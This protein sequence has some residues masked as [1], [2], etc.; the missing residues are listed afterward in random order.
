MTTKIVDEIGELVRLAN[1]ARDLATAAIQRLVTRRAMTDP[2]HRAEVQRLLD[3]VDPI[4]VPHPQLRIVERH[5]L[6]VHRAISFHAIMLQRSEA[7][8]HLGIRD[9]AWLLDDKAVGHKF[10]DALGVRRPRGDLVPRRI[11]EVVPEPPCVVKPVRA[12]G[13]TGVFVVYQPDRILELRTN[14]L[15]RSWEEVLERARALLDN[16]LYPRKDSWLVEELI[17]DG[18]DL[19]RDLKFFCAYGEVVGALEIVRLPQP[20]WCWWT[21]DGKIAETGKPTLLPKREAVGISREQFAKAAAIS[22]EIPA[23]FMRIDCLRQGRKDFVVC[24]FTPRPGQF[25][26]FNH[27]YDRLLG[28]AYLRAE[29]R[30][31]DDL[32]AGRRFTAWEKAVGRP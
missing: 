2:Q 14:K 26:E 4:A 6:S 30:L 7:M 3:H 12:T 18:R 17:L 13:A 10:C 15:F 11:A 1:A 32:F 5:K 25:E 19:A 28:E 31:L 23:P 22:A 24:E 8:K 27:T 21:P 16:P 20:R 9:R 29:R